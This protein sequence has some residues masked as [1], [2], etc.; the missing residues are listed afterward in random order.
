MIVYEFITEAPMA[1]EQNIIYGVYLNRQNDIIA[2]SSAYKQNYE[3]H[4]IR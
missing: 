4:N 3:R 2:Q 1:L